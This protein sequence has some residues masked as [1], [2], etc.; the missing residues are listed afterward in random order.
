[1]VNERNGCPHCGVDMNPTTGDKLLDD[2]FNTMRRVTYN[3]C[4]SERGNKTGYGID[5]LDVVSKWMYDV[6]AVHPSMKIRVPL[7]IIHNNNPPTC[8]ELLTCPVYTDVPTVRA[9]LQR[10]H[11]SLQLQH[12]KY[13]C[14]WVHDAERWLKNN[15]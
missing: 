4:D 2:A 8:D 3:V 9:W 15:T 14:G 12:N 7:E 10:G 1:M 5:T 13:V 6:I 11:T